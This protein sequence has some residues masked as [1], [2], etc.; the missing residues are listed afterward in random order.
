MGKEKRAIVC[1]WRCWF[2]IASLVI[3]VGIYMPSA[4]AQ[5]SNQHNKPSENG[6]SA[7][8]VARPANPSVNPVT[9]AAVKLGILSSLK[10]INQVTT[11]LTANTKSGVL[12]SPAKNQPDQHIF[13]TSFEIL[14]PDNSTIYASASFSRTTTP[15]TIRFNMLTKHQSSCK[16]QSL[17]I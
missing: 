8:A 14:P 6:G 3:C 7:P 2:S 16:K 11:F 1:S 4:S 10:R 17:N 15:C 13:S 5:D 9:Q 12:I